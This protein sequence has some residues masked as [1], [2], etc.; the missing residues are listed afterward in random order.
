MKFLRINMSDYE[1]ILA[2]LERQYP[3]RLLIGVKELAAIFDL[4]EKTVYNMTCRKASKKFP[5]KAAKVPGKKFKLTD[6]AR[7]LAEV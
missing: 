4:S 6:I 2:S 3:G 7:A 1:S 5:V